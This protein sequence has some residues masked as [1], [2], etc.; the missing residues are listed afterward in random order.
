M[1]LLLCAS[2][3]GGPIVTNSEA[4]DLTIFN[5][6][7]C[8]GGVVSDCCCDEVVCGGIGCR[9]SSVVDCE[10]PISEQTS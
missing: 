6:G 5:V 4:S 9:A 3:P 2:N 7:N 10:E 8:E 1:L